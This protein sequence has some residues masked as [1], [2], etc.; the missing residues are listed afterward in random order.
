[1]KR[2]VVVMLVILLAILVTLTPRAASVTKIAVCQAGYSANQIKIAVAVVTG[3]TLSDT[4]Y[5]IVKAGDGTQV[6]TGTMT[7]YTPSGWTRGETY[8]KIDFT[9][10]TT[11]GDYKIK[12]NGVTSRQFTFSG[13]IWTNYLDEMVEYYRIQR[14]GVNTNNILPSSGFPNRPSA[15]ALHAAC[16]MDDAKKGSESGSSADMTGGWHD[17]GDNNKYQSNTGWV[18]GALA[19]TFLRHPNATFDF[20]GNGVPDLLDEARW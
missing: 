9:P 1:M 5:Q 2:Q 12:T 15:E 8:Y 6:Y 18:T 10:F 4:S 13:N 19:V 3:G 20:D 7:A 11:P 14:C 17:A 16:H